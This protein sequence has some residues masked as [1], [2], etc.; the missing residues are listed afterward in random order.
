MRLSGVSLAELRAKL[1]AHVLFSMRTAIEAVARARAQITTLEEA[2]NAD[3]ERL[4]AARDAVASASAPVARYL[5][6]E[7]GA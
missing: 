2:M 5:G 3:Q 1:I 6:D 7:P 4:M